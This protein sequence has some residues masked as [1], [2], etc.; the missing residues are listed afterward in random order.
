MVILN[1]IITI[2]QPAS[3]TEEYPAQRCSKDVSKLHGLLYTHYVLT[4]YAKMDFLHY[5]W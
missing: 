2:P 1:N 3:V 4:F 5:I